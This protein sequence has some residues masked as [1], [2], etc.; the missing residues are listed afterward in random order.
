MELTIP[1]DCSAATYRNETA[2]GAITGSILRPDQHWG[3]VH[4]MEFA[5]NVK[6]DACISSGGE[7]AYD[8]RQ[9]VSVGDG[10]TAVP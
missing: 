7:P 3:S 8:A 6:R 5:P 4:Q 1:F 2:E 9:R 10:N